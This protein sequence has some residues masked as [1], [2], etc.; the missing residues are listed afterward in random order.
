MISPVSAPQ[1]GHRPELDALG[2]ELLL[3]ERGDL[4]DGLAGEVVD[5]AS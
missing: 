1:R 2:P 3:V 5:A 4:L